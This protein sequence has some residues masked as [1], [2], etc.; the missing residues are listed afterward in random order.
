[1][2]RWQTTDKQKATDG[3]I[4]TNESAQMIKAIFKIE[5]TLFGHSIWDV[6]IHTIKNTYTFTMA[7]LLDFHSFKLIANY[8]NK[9][10]IFL[11]RKKSKDSELVKYF[12]FF[13]F[14]CF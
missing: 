1:M 11:Q 7:I 12:C 13:L 9:K 4:R 6:Y 3:D 5:Q 10:D 14:F 2:D 8:L